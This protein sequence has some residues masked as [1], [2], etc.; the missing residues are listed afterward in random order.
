ME[1]HPDNQYTKHD[2][3][4][5][6]FV[7][8]LSTKTFH[9]DDN[10]DDDEE[11]EDD[12]GDSLLIDCFSTKTFHQVDAVVDSRHPCV[13]SFLVWSDLLLLILIVC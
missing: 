10:D 13:P 9:Q 6:L 1:I 11:E 2:D 5:S 8:G 7:D 12:D 4:D 3:D